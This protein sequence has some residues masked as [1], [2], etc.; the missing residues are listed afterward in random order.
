[1]KKLLVLIVTALVIMLSAPVY[2]QNIDKQDLERISTLVSELPEDTNYTRILWE[3]NISYDISDIGMSK[4]FRNDYD[5]SY[6]GIR[7]WILDEVK[8]GLKM[9]GNEVKVIVRKR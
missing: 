7:Y 3:M 6:E 9:E 1:M 4:I 5:Y 2:A 8:V